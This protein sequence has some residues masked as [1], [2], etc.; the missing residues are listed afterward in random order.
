MELSVHLRL[1]VHPHLCMPSHFPISAHLS[2]M[3][4]ID[5][6]LYNLKLYFRQ[7]Q[8]HTPPIY[9][10]FSSFVGNLNLS[11]SAWDLDCCHSHFILGREEARM[12]F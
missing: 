7:V 2:C 10:K 6:R 3:T 11:S 8:C 9:L 4:F 1:S 5:S 12:G